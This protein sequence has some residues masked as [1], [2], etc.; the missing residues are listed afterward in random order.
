MG[1]ILTRHRTAAPSVIVVC[2]AWSFALSGCGGA[3]PVPKPVDAAATAVGWPA[4]WNR[5]VGKRIT[6]DGYAHDLKR[7]PVV[8]AEPSF[9]S[10]RAVWIEGLPGWPEGVGGATSAHVRVTGTVIK[11]DDMPVY[12]YGTHG[13]N[14]APGHWVSTEEELNRLKWRF[15][16]KDATWTVVD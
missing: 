3:Q 1:A 15:L 8:T 6:I 11:R 13:D 9:A 12:L 10:T 14:G 4:D 16:L 5:L 2:A 7:G